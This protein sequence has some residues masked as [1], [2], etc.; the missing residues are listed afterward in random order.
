MEQKGR[1]SYLHATQHHPIWARAQSRKP[2]HGSYPMAHARKRIEWFQVFRSRVGSIGA[3][4]ETHQLTHWCLSLPSLLNELTYWTSPMATGYRPFHQ[5]KWRAGPH[6]LPLQ[7]VDEALLIEHKG[8]HAC[9][10]DSTVSLCSW[11]CV[12]QRVSQR[13]QLWA[14]TR[15]PGALVSGPYLLHLQIKK[16]TLAAH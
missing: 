6:H 15:H 9:A 13:Q 7:M 14:G 11:F 2:P 16:S 12:Q 4:G 1:C 8:S 3:M 5:T 10:W